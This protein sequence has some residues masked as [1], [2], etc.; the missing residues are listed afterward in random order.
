MTSTDAARKQILTI[1]ADGQPHPWG[2]IG[3]AVALT[4][5]ISQKAVSSL[6][7]HLHHTGEIIRDNP[8]DREQTVRLPGGSE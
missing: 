6:L 8:G 5:G 2:D 3:R 4:H 1:L 7:R